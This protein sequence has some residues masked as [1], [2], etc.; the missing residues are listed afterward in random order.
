MKSLSERILNRLSK[1]ERIETN[2]EIARALKASPAQVS[3]VTC[4]LAKMGKIDR[5]KGLLGGPWLYYMDTRYD[6]SR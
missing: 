5:V 4:R 6:H 1:M 3:S 2:T